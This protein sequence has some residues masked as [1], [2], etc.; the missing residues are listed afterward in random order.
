MHMADIHSSIVQAICMVQSSIGSVAKDSRNQHGGYNFASTD[1]VYAMVTKK[2]AEAGLM[3][4]C[5][6]DGTPEIK[7]V[8]TKDAKGDAKISQWGLFVFQFV[9]ATSEATWTDKNCRR[10]LFLQLTGPQSFMAA[11]SYAE[12]AFLRSLFKLPTGDA[13]LDG[14]PQADFEDEQVAMTG[15]RGKRKASAEGKRDGSVKV[16]NDLRAKIQQCP[17]RDT[18]M[19][20]RRQFAHDWNEM[21]DRWAATL[22][23]DY[24][25]RMMGF[26]ERMS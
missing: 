23:E 6:E 19:M 3:V 9:L 20:M 26:A 17:D 24:E 1:A 22:D 12:K 25:A 10:S 11:Q 16:F 15:P 14:L 21:P 7:R 5:L 13:D 18:L 8:E 4:L 2:M